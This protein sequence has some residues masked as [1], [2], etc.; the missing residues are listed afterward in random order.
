[1]RLI[2]VRDP[3]GLT[4]F[5]D[6]PW[7]I[8]PGRFPAWVPP[9]RRE[10]RAFL[11]PRRNP[12]F[13]HAEVRLFLVEDAH[14]TCLGRIA[15]IVNHRHN[16]IH[17]DRTGF[18]GLFECTD[19][20]AAAAMLFAAAADFLRG[21]GLTVMRGPM[22]LSIN[23]EA[24]LL[25][26]GFEHPPMVL[27][28]Y[29]PPYY[30]GLVTA[31]GFRPVMNLIAYHTESNREVP[32]RVE[33]AAAHARKRYGFVVRPVKWRDFDREVRRV[34]EI[35]SAAWAEN[36]G[37]VAM[38]D[39]EFDHLAGQLREIIDP[40]LCFVAEVDGRIAGFSLAL[41]DI[42]QAL[43]PMNGRLFPFG[44]LLFLWHR[45]RINAVRII[46]LGVLKEFRHLG[47]EACFYAETHRQARAK[48]LVHAEA[49]WILE[50]NVPMNRALVKMGFRIAKTYRVYDRALA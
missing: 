39:R 9:L 17:R 45:R 21:R 18:F 31:G 16:T 20:P 25:V 42:N 11:D 48:G 36:W 35:Y 4:R 23:D 44:L 49:S 27:M 7:R 43:R 37:A 19:D 22:N 29:N 46:T 41:P 3:R 30:E 8:Y 13:D 38:T 33:R 34:Q 32:E 40:D 24:G 15:G 1:M 5:I 10:R 14:G 50:N 12:F 26:A 2:E 28:P 6:L 47:I